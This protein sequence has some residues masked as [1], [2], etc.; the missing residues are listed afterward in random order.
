MKCLILVNA[1][2]ETPGTRQVLRMREELK[3]LGVATEI[4]RNDFFCA[5][6]ADGDI[7]L[8][9]DLDFCVYLD[10]DKYV[11]R[12]LEKRGIR[13]FNSAAAVEACDDKMTTHI[14]L[15][16]TGIAMPD[17]L[18]GLLCY[19]ANA[20]LNAAALDKA[21]RLLGYPVIVKQ[22]FGSIG[23]GV[24]KA[25]DRPALDAVAEKVKTS[26]HLFQKFI[27]S[28]YGRDMRVIV[29]G[30]KVVGGIERRSN[31]DF[32]SNVGL[33]GSATAVTVP[34]EVRAAAVKAAKVLGLDY[35]GMDF[36]YGE[37]MLLCEVNSNAYF[38]AFERVTNINVAKLYAEHIVRSL[39]NRP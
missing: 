24:F 29:I 4:R 34:E 8:D 35:C 10:K 17:T 12:M 39:D 14:I 31:G 5:R 28:S 26:P 27:A 30:G 21:E 22:S 38:D 32:R 9:A 37:K 3:K 1:F 33:G 23:N 2:A 11:P 6:I 16:G 20:K 25:D 13:L 7:L 19:E 36:L 18:P 15:A